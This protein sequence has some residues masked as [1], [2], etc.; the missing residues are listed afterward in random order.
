MKLPLL[1]ML[2]PLATLHAQASPDDLDPSFGT[3]GQRFLQ[4]QDD[5][6]Y[7]YGCYA[8]G[9]NLLLLPNGDI[10]VTG[11]S[12]MRVSANAERTETFDLAVACG[13]MPGKQCPI[14]PTAPALQADGKI[15]IPFTMGPT[16]GD[17][18]RIGVVR[19]QADFSPDLAFGI[20]GTASLSTIF[21]Y[22]THRPLGLAVQ[23]DGGLLVV[24]SSNR[25]LVL[26][27]FLA[28]G[29]PDRTFGEGGLL[30][31][32]HVD[33]VAFV[34]TST[35]KLVVASPQALMRLL[36][37]GQVD[38]AF[39]ARD[40]L[41]GAPLFSALALA[42]QADGKIVVA[43]LLYRSG[44]VFSATIALM[45]LD[46]QGRRDDAFGTGGMV[47]LPLE[48]DRAF[49]GI[50]LAMALDSRARIV[51][52]ATVMPINPMVWRGSRIAV[53]RLLP[54]G[55]ADTFFAGGGLATLQTPDALAN[56]AMAITPADAILIGATDGFPGPPVHGPALLRLHGGEGSV[57]RPVRE[58]RAVEF[59]HA[60]FGHYVIAATQR[61]IATL[62]DPLYDPSKAWR[63]TGGAFRVWSGE[64]PELSAV[65]RFFSGQSFAPKSS[66]FFT[67]YAQECASLR[68]G[69]TWTFEG[70]P[71]R[72]RLPAAAPAGLGCPAG[73]AALYRAYN[74]GLG[75]APNHRYTDDPAV[76]ASMLAQGW[77][78][79]GDAETRVFACIPLP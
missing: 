46:A 50:G 60:V 47:V 70:E 3:G 74:N 79:E 77:A 63:R 75:G 48:G 9:I 14:S 24:G 55:V 68:A 15:V 32:D 25:D 26:T 18:T 57:N 16:M 11:P 2:L 20:A 71:F 22:S 58:E 42:A 5:C 52:S 37:N 54:D 1:L 19:L 7:Y 67:P 49:T 43:G 13:T 23:A 6:D 39:D 10:A 61:E 69:S 12:L 30:R 34:Q 4:V 35:G 27:R 31:V 33:P 76:L 38:D 59:Y 78:F 73:S 40:A 64:A 44:E 56:E 21:R 51:V 8:G 66:H 53:A 72:L 62:D 28:A 45:R 41:L 29:E 36:P 65:C 17:P